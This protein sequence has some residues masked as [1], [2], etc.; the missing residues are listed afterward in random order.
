MALL[1]LQGLE[2]AP[3]DRTSGDSRASLLLCGDSG[4]SVTTCN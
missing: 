3:A 2:L 4:L 1:D